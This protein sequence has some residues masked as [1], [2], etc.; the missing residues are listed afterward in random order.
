M[1]CQTIL[2]KWFFGLK[3]AVY[4]EAIAMYFHMWRFQVFARKLSWYIFHWCL[5]NKYIYIYIY[6]YIFF[7]FFFLC[8]RRSIRKEWISTFFGIIWW[9]LPNVGLKQNEV[10]NIVQA[11]KCPEV[12]TFWRLFYR[13]NWMAKVSYLLSH[14][15]A[16]WII[17]VYNLP[18]ATICWAL[19]RALY[20][21]A[22]A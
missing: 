2:L 7:V 17:Y 11:K 10:L 21:E 14:L 15:N 1:K 16:L 12:P 3:G 4:S 5:Y 6:I 9:S 19:S 13:P 8:C 18:K 22:I 20:T